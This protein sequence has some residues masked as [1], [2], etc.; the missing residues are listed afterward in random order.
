MFSKYFIER[1][2]LANVIAVL[3]VLLGAVAL[4]TLPV[5]QYPNI[6]PPTVQVT[7]SYPGANA[8]TV[9]ESIALPI[10]E[11]VN[12][13]ENMLYMQS[14][15]A[16]DGS[17]SLTVTFAVGTNGDT[18]QVLVQNRVS[19]ALSKLPAAVQ[20]QGVTT[21]KRSASILQ[22]IALTS[23]DDRYDNLYLSNYA[24]INLIDELSRLP[25]VGSVEVLGSQYAMRIWLDPHLLRARG[26][27]PADV[28][29]AIKSQNQEVA[30][31]QIG[32]P[33]A[34]K[35]Q[36][37]QLTVDVPGRLADVKQFEN[38]IVK[39][40]P[41]DGG[42][43]IR[44]RDL[45]RVELGAQAYTKISRF[46]NRPTALIAVYQRPE[47]NALDVAAEVKAAF[48]RLSTQFPEAL[49]YRVTVDT[50]RFVTESI[51]QV[52]KTLIE[53]GVLVLLVILAFLQN[54]RAVLIPMTTIPV[55]IIG[56]FAAMSL[57]GFSVNML[58]LFALVLAIGIVV[59][60]AIIVVE[61]AAHH[62]EQGR[63]P[64]EAATRAMTELFG[65]II[66]ITLVLIAVFVPAAFISGITGQLY[67]QFA[68]VIAATAVLSAINAATLKPT[69]CALWM[70]PASGRKR[71]AARTFNAG[72]DVLE[73]GYTHLI[74]FMVRRA[75][76]MSLLAC[77][78]I[79][80]AGYGL[81]RI[82]TGFLPT[83]DQGYVMIGVQ[84]P[85]GASLER[86]TA[87][88]EKVSKIAK[89][90]PGVDQVIS[91]AGLSV[92]DN[93]ATLSNGGVAWAVL[94]DWGERTTTET[95]LQGIVEHLQRAL[96]EIH[97]G[98]T[99]V[100]VPPAI[101]GLGNTGGFSMMLQLRDGSF[102]YR[103]LEALGSALVANA[104][105][106]SGL[107]QLATSF[108][109]QAPQRIVE[110]DRVKAE[111]LQVAVTDVFSTMQAILGSSYVGQITKFGR[112]FQ[113][114]IQGDDNFRTKVE[115]L[116]NF[117]V[118]NQAGEMIPLGTLV[119]V[120]ESVGPSVINLYN[121]RPAA[122]VTGGAAEGSALVKR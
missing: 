17:Y 8:A 65:P 105:A 97:E 21:E 49:E 34:P 62:M 36:Q 5:A 96:G 41:G 40:E 4:M 101:Q 63:T 26:L 92:L 61:G 114:Y 89:A 15:S 16:N 79:L 23:Q 71:W 74:R 103:R 86:T 43:V 38:I 116:L 53:A 120:K 102:D 28:S 18:A 54:W 13:V 66:G 91:V 50:T 44:L 11:S 122:L 3:M 20:A 90:T 29:T 84:L 57:M 108:R 56:A 110:V 59:D 72:F 87:A 51:K 1:P 52:Y 81:S 45:G 55:T 107:S 94:R 22:L 118:R 47:A 115:H 73:R 93:M 19:A 10:E 121:L 113:V 69:Q 76:V 42:R 48:E 9:A 14:T 78:I 111:A 33:P 85:D 39:V 58:T 68:L 32:F 24:T 82:P 6:V 27:T 31:G 25:G 119:T 64:K 35:G 30:A 83:E 88:M 7:T 99:F 112:V 106:Q 80:G 60:D 75:A 95:S 109:A 12:G 2:I 70:R 100:L 46:E 77:L 117:H 98:A 67:R 37:F 104:S